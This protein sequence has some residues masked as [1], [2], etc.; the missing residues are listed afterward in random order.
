LELPDGARVLEVGAGAGLTGVALADRG[1][2]VTAV[3]SSAAMTETIRGRAAEA[4]VA[5]RLQV[6]LGDAHRLPFADGA[7]GLVVALGVI[8]W[9]H[10]PERAARELARVLTPGGYL[11]VSADNR[12][13]S[14]TYSTRGTAR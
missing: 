13:A 4:A 6:S 14:P 10:S 12:A 11:V 9:L 3:D 5:S 1:Y 7:F 8:P 2:Q